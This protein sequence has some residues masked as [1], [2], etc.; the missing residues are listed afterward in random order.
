M[1]RWRIAFGFAKEVDAHLR[2]LVAA[3]VVDPAAARQALGLLDEVRAITWR[4]LHP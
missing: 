4:L 2:L 3:G 1:Q